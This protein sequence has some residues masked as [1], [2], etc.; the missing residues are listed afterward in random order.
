M[1]IKGVAGF[2]GFHFIEY[3]NAKDSDGI[4]FDI[5]SSNNN[6]RLMQAQFIKYGSL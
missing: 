5:Y 6:C 3:L 4:I 1:F 2:I